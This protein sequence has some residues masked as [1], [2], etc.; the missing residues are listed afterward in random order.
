MIFLL[1]TERVFYETF[2]LA[3]LLLAKRF[4]VPPD[5]VKAEAHVDGNKIVPRF[6]VQVPIAGPLEKQIVEDRIRETW[7]AVKPVLME[8]LHGVL[9]ARYGTP[10]AIQTASGATA[11]NLGETGSPAA[12]GSDSAAV[13]GNGG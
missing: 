10:K 12:C 3:R 13:S 11:A 8:R 2:E 6:D 5:L 9:E 7:M 4:D 1:N